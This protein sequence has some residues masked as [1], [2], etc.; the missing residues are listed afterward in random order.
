MVKSKSKRKNKNNSKKNRKKKSK[1]TNK[2]VKQKWYHSSHSSKFNML[3]SKYIYSDGWVSSNAILEYVKNTKDI[4]LISLVIKFVDEMDVKLLIKIYEYGMQLNKTKKYNKICYEKIRSFIEHERFEQHIF[5]KD[6]EHELMSYYE[7][8]KD[9][10]KENEI[11]Y[12]SW[13]KNEKGNWLQKHSDIDNNKKVPEIKNWENHK[14]KFKDIHE[15]IK[16]NNNQRKIE[17]NEHLKNLKIMKMIENDF[18][19]QMIVNHKLEELKNSLIAN[20]IKQ[21]KEMQDTQKY[22]WENKEH[23]IVYFGDY[24]IKNKHWFEL[25]ILNDKNKAINYAV[26]RLRENPYLIDGA[27]TQDRSRIYNATIY[28]NIISYGD[29]EEDLLKEFEEILLISGNDIIDYKININFKL[30]WSWT[31]NIKFKDNLFVKESRSPAQKTNIPHVY[32]VYIGNQPINHLEYWSIN[33]MDELDEAIELA[34]S[35]THNEIIDI[36]NVN[37]INRQN[38]V[39]V[40]RRK[41]DNKELYEQMVC[42]EKTYTLEEWKQVF[43]EITN[44]PTQSE[45][46]LIWNW[47][48][49]FRID[50]N[51]TIHGDEKY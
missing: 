17:E 44:N 31:P 24:E 47:V 28:K 41:I 11:K 14:V 49:D 34:E 36:E 13:E 43:N 32:F 22:L 1:R 27:N 46:E 10:T 3:L 2:K 48:V 26:K 12:W 30:S 45:Y 35:N 8:D 16:H 21:I 50:E 7:L 38:Y 37:G 18:E 42:K 20:K 4:K 15:E 29:T 19:F 9:K 6:L 40:Y 39:F 23:Y 25:K 33:V 5:V 51:V